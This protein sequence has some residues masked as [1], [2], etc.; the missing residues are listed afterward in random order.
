MTG[1]LLLLAVSAVAFLIGRGLFAIGVRNGDR[2][3]DVTVGVAEPDDSGRGISFAVRNPG[4]QP[5][6]VGA[7]MRRRSLR[8]RGEAGQLVTVPRRT[9]RKKLLAGQ[10]TVLCAIRA[11]EAAT[12]VVPFSR[13][14][15]RWAE[16]VVVIGEPDRL[17]VVRRSVE[18][19]RPWRSRGFRFW[20]D[21][22]QRSPITPL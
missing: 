2:L 22:A 13:S 1:L 11:S 17:R 21:R 14:T 12:V 6:L 18:L 9:S 19:S 4:P 16:L 7:S 3:G 10:H 8:L 15:G 5:V 20:R